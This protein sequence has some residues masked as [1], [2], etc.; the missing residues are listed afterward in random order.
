MQH[1][2]RLLSLDLLAG[3]S[4]SRQS[5]FERKKNNVFEHYPARLC[6]RIGR[7]FSAI[8]KLDGLRTVRRHPGSIGFRRHSPRFRKKRTLSWYATGL[9][10]TALLTREGSRERQA[11]HE[12]A[13][14]CSREFQNT[15]CAWKYRLVMARPDDER[16]VLPHRADRRILGAEQT[17]DMNDRSAKVEAK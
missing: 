13:T 16:G 2:R 14:T 1:N 9:E 12:M 7:L 10:P 17:C 5:Q 6:L 3:P 11:N 4:P 15:R 8:R